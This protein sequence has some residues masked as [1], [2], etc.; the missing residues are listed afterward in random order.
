MNGMSE[1]EARAMFAKLAA[2]FPAARR[3]DATTKVYV[4]AFQ[5]CKPD[6]ALRA[7]NVLIGTHKDSRSLPS[8]GAIL[9][10]YRRPEKVDDSRGLPLPRLSAA[11]VA[12]NTARLEALK[13]WMDNPEREDWRLLVD[14]MGCAANLGL[15][16]HAEL[17][18]L[19]ADA[20]RTSGRPQDSRP[21]GA[22]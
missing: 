2:A 13:S 9:E 20:D 5:K 15:H 22:G 11:E 3:E 21:V 17:V 8:V 18:R 7:V 19:R 4:E 1:Q 6:A 16:D 12:V 10:E 14:R